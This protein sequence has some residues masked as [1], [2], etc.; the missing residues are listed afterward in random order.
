MRISFICPGHNSLGTIE[1]HFGSPER[2][3]AFPPKGLKVGYAVAHEKVAGH[4]C[5]IWRSIRAGETRRKRQR[6]NP[7]G[8]QRALPG[9]ANA[10]HVDGPLWSP[11]HRFAES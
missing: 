8:S 3:A 7:P 4:P 6:T 2:P 1:A 9:D 5:T 11:S 10:A